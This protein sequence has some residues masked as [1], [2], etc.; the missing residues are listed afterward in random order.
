MSSPHQ[1]ARG[2]VSGLHR[3][4]AVDDPL[5]PGSRLQLSDVVAT[6]AALDAQISGGPLLNVAG[7]VVGLSFAASYQGRSLP[8]AV[9]TVGLP[10]EIDKM[11]KTGHLL[12]PSLG[13]EGLDLSPEE[14]ALRG[15]PVGTLVQS[16][17]SGGPAERAGIRAGDVLLQIDDVRLDPTHPLGEVVRTRLAPSQ[18]ITVTLARG[19]SS[20]QVVLIL[21]QEHPACS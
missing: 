2:I 17:A 12:L 21:G 15:L 6:D 13:L 11:V 16:V 20:T 3:D 4:L 9:S 19:S 8:L 7:Q 10:S 5:A 1:V 18:R 14:G